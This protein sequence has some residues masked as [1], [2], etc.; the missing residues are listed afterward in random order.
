[1]LIKPRELLKDLSN[2]VEDFQDLALSNSELAIL[3][4][5][6]IFQPEYL[7]DVIF[8][9]FSFKYF[10]LRMQISSI[11]MPNYGPF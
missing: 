2:L 10:F 5:I 7:P 11:L 8:L 4:A 6:L 9:N 3:S 1:M